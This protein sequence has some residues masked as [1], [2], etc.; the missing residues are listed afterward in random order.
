M[1]VLSRTLFVGGVTSSE[2]HLRSLFARFGLVQ[3]CIVNVD[4]RH[5]FIKMLNRKDAEKA[6]T[7]MEEYKDGN[8][9]LRVCIVS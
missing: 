3:T 5:A 1:K 7:G 2:P 4:K 8:T 6:R 9:Q